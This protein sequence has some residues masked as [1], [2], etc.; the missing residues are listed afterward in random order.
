MLLPTKWAM[1]GI[2]K[3]VSMLEQKEWV[4]PESR[5]DLLLLVLSILQH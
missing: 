2:K 1:T 4:E 3:K 5:I